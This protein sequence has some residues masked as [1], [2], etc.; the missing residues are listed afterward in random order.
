MDISQALSHRQFSRT[1]VT[2]DRKTGLGGWETF[3]E[4]VFE[5]RVTPRLGVE[6]RAFALIIGLIGKLLPAERASRRQMISAF[7]SV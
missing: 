2:R 1:P 4:I 7:K 3:S 5:F 6:G